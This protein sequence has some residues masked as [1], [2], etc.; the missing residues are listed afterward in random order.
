MWWSIVEERKKFDGE[1]TKIGRKNGWLG[2]FIAHIYL[3]FC[4]YWN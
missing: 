3:I 4:N 1:R 2:Q